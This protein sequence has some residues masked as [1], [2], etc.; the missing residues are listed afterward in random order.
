MIRARIGALY[1]YGIYI[2]DSEVIQFGFPPVNG[3][4][5]NADEVKVVST[6]VDAFRCDNFL[7]AAELGFFEKRKARPAEKRIEY[8]RSCV[9][10]GGYDLLDNNCEHFAYEC[11]FGKGRS[12]QSEKAKNLLG[13]MMRRD[14]KR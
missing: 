12:S 13:N 2:S 4:P 14:G 5:R 11:V 1:H 3:T 9:G 10:K 7:E 8:A 6:D